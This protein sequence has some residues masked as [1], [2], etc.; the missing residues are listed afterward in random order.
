MRLF[1]DYESKSIVDYL[2]SIVPLFLSLAVATFAGLQWK[3]SNN[4][5]R[6]DLFEKRYKVYQAA[7]DLLRL[8]VREGKVEFADLAAFNFEVA[9]AEFLFR[10]DVLEYLNRLRR[11]AAHLKTTQTL[12]SGRQTDDQL[13]KTADAEEKD[14]LELTEQLDNLTKVFGRYLGFADIARRR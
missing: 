9:D 13:E 12:L 6:L 8:V 11:K 7:R 14:L 4:K 3:V 5:L 10:S 1:F 2:I